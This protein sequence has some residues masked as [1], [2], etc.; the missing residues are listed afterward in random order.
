MNR[1][2]TYLFLFLLLSLTGRSQ[3]ASKIPLYLNDLKQAANDSARVEAYRDL[4][5]NYST[6]NT[7]S[8]IYFGK[9][10]LALALSIKFI[11]GIGDCYNSLGWCYTRKGEFV[12]AKKCLLLALNYFNQTGNRCHT[13]VALSNLGGMYFN[14]NQLADALEYY[15]KCIQL[16]KGCPESWLLPG[17]LYSIGIVYNS[18][19]EF[20]IAIPYF[21]QAMEIN[22]LNNDSNKL[23]DCINGLGNAYLGLKQLDSAAFYLNQSSAMYHTLGNVSGE[24]YALESIGS[25]HLEHGRINEALKFFE[26]AR[27][28]FEKSGSKADVCYELIMIGNVYQKQGKINSAITYMQMALQIAERNKF[29]S[30]ES[31][32]LNSLSDLYASKGDY[33][34]A[35]DFFKRESA[36]KDSTRESQQQIRLDDL[37]TKYETEQKDKMIELLNRDKSIEKANAEWQRLLKNIFIAGAVMLFLILLVIYNRFRLKR[38]T[39]K[40]LEQKNKIIAYEKDRAESSERFK[41]QFLANMSH[42]IRT[43]LNAIIGMTELLQETKQDELNEKYIQIIKNSSDGLLVIINDILDLSKIEAGKMELEKIPFRFQDILDHVYEVFSKKA[44]TKGVDFKFDVSEDIPEFIIADPFRITQ[45]LINI[46]GNAIKFTDNG[47]VIVSVRKTQSLQSQNKDLCRL[48]FEVSDSGIGIPKNQ[49]ERIFDSFIQTNTYNTRKYGGTGLGLTI[50]QSL[51]RLM[52][53]NIDVSSVENQGTTFSFNIDVEKSA[54]IPEAK[55]TEHIPIS[56]DSVKKDFSILLV[57][58]NEYNQILVKDALKKKIPEVKLHIV[59]SGL[60]AIAALQT[61]RFNLILMDISMLEMDGYELT[62]IIRNDL[63][64]ATS[65][66]PIV[67]LTANVSQHE[68]DKCLSAGMNDYLTKPFKIQELVDVVNRFRFNPKDEAGSEVTEKTYKS[69]DI[70]LSYLIDFTDGDITEMSRYVD[71]YL[72]RIPEVFR[73]VEMALKNNEV[74]QIIVLLHSIKPMIASVGLRNCEQKISEIESQRESIKK[75]KLMPVIL[76]IRKQCLEMVDKL[77]QW[78]QKNKID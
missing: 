64:E 43:P 74:K 1:F 2:V 67:A 76:Q 4:C 22:I 69:A 21:G 36:I 17:S 25:L 28:N 70:D 41:Q 51:V 5:F 3:D 18:Q 48:Q 15:L 7:D 65:K 37:K 19:K 49:Q 46:V 23:A 56:A 11:K 40:K 60:E 52:G 14:Q 38:E 26:M 73:E 53:G 30:L 57:E 31:Q 62:A 10:G 54:L 55:K 13:A 50:S 35:F 33:K 12:E 47:F 72:Q 61:C 6:T 24:A 32:V 75:N 34:N 42:E 63:N 71:I 45:V 9:K 66:I 58:D 16:S 29:S 20:K 78:K 39:A 59:R 44:S 68:Y 8:G 77:N 27:T